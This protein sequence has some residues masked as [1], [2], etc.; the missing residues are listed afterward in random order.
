[1]LLFEVGIGQAADVEQILA[2]CGY[3]DIETFQDT[4]GIWRVV[5]GTANQ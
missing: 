2:R 3:E 5:K 1:M 4:G